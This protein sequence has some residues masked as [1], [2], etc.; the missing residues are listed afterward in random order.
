MNAAAVAAA[1]RRFLKIVRSS[2]GAR[3]AALDHEEQ[4]AAGSAARSEPADHDGVVPAGDAALRD[5]EHEPGQSDDERHGAGDVE[6]RS[7]SAA[8]RARAGRG[9]PR[10]RRAQPSGTLNQN[11][12]CQPIVTSAPPSTGPS[13]SPIAAT[14]VF[15]PIARPSSSLRERV[16]DERGRVREQE[17]ARRRPAAIRQQDQLGAAR[18]EAGAERRQRE[19]DEARRRR[20]ACGRTGRTGGPAVST[21]TVDAMM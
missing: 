20:R 19:H 15:V 18:R 17:R 6:P 7:V 5:A 10:A 2:I 13:T 8:G 21:S 14:I 16:G 1:N 11:T 9:R 12:H 3:D 4:P